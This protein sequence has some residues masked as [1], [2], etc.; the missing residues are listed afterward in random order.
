MND[1]PILQGD[2]LPIQMEESFRWK[3]KACIEECEGFCCKDRSYLM[4]SFH[5]ILMILKSPYAKIIGIKNTCELFEDNPP[6]LRIKKSQNFEIVIPN[7]CFRPI[8]AKMGALPEHA[9]SNICPFLKPLGMVYDYHKEK[10]PNTAHPLA[11]G[12]ILKD[13]KPDICKFSPIGPM[14]SMETGRLSYC[15]VQ[16]YEVCPACNSNGKVELK[17][18]LKSLRGVNIGSKSLFHKVAMRHY[19]R[20]Q[21]GH[22]QSNFNQVLRKVYNIDR[23]LLDNNY[24]V[25]SRP[26]Y[27]LLMSIL[28]EAAS[29]KFDLW[30]A[31]VNHL[32]KGNIELF[33]RDK[34]NRKCLDY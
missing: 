28:Y 31:F 22:D 12:C 2:E 13:H 33:M 20:V 34:D 19:R 32:T 14:R 16:P 5:D 7:I 11:M 10:I 9:P 1:E 6:L 18:Y 30:E 4:I 29:G 8:G 21:S 25:Q 24:N 27:R 15:H 3:D 23:L 17:T 26:S